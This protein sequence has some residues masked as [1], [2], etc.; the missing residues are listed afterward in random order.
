MNISSISISYFLLI[1]S[2]IALAFFLYFKIILLKANDSEENRNK[3]IGAAKDAEGWEKRN[4]LMCY[5]SLFWC[6]I[7]MGGFIFLKYFYPPALF[8][9]NYLY[10][11]IAIIVLSNFIIYFNKEKTVQ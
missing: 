8:S 3:I 10:L 1:I 2:I 6:V 5:L 7:S 11:Y 9:L 4:N